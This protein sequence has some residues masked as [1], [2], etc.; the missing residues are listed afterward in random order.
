MS[1]LSIVVPVLN[2]RGN[3]PTLVD[4]LE[5][6]LGTLD[7]EIVF[8]D[9]DS[10]DGTAD[11]CRR[12]AQSNPRV[13]ILQRI[14]RIGLASACVEG[15]LA[16]SS[17]YI[18]VMD[19]DLQHDENQ[20]PG[21]F[22]LARDRH[23]DIV[24]GSRNLDAGGMGEFPEHRVRLSNLGK[25]LSSRLLRCDVSD[26]MSG[27]FLMDRN[28]FQEVVHDL[29]QIGFKILLDLIA[30]CKRQGAACWKFPTFSASD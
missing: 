6:A 27:F 16:T 8:V 13:R 26:P 20:I 11:V 25:H 2:E 4:R 1:D 29:S 3:I 30:S 22:R 5:R 19:G 24:I 10:A 14:G 23:L 7:W 17:R 9:D 15:I 28:Y 12:I 18:A 21:M